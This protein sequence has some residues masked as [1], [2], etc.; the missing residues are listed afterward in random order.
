MQVAA[1]TRGAQVIILWK[2]ALANP[3]EF[4]FSFS[5]SLELRIAAS[6]TGWQQVSTFP[7][8][9]D[10]VSSSNLLFDLGKFSPFKFLD[11][12]S[13]DKAHSNDTL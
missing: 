7:T 9:S 1:P 4:L 13:F 11:P 12:P 5:S 2:Q 6:S 10:A 8:H 3:S